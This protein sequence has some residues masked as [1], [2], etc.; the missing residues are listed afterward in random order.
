MNTENEF[1]YDP[2]DEPPVSVGAALLLL[3]PFVGMVLAF[4]IYIIESGW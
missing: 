2:G 1:E 3:A 4:G